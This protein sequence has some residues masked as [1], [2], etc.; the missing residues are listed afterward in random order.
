MPNSSF[1]L[2]SGERTGLTF[3]V[4]FITGERLFASFLPFLL[5]ELVLAPERL[6]SEGMARA[7]LLFGRLSWV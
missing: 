3:K 5:W 1:S 7:L 6:T 2:L 4:L